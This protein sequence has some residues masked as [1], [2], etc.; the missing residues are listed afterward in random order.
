MGMGRILLREVHWRL[1]KI[2]TT[3]V[4][5]ALPVYITLDFVYIHIWFNIEDAVIVP[6]I[7][8]AIMAA[9]GGCLTF[10]Q[11]RQKHLKQSRTANKSYLK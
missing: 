9:G 5:F 1:A 3:L 8:G 6:I 2:V 10:I 7:Q 4:M 11:Q